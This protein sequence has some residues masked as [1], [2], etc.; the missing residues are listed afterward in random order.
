MRSD[1]A[2]AEGAHFMRKMALVLAM[3][4]GVTLLLLVFGAT[5]EAAAQATGCCQVT[6]TSCASPVTAAQCTGTFLAGE[7]CRTSIGVCGQPMPAPFPGWAAMAL[8]GFVAVAGGVIAGRRA[9][10]RP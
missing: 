9:L 1:G 2:T 4:M 3:A 8:A 5:R 6:S 10:V 7:V